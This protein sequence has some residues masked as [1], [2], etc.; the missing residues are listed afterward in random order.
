MVMKVHIDFDK[1]IWA[2]IFF[3]GIVS[4][5]IGAFFNVRW[6][7]DQIRFIK[8]AETSK[9]K[10]KEFA[11]SLFPFFIFL[12]IIAVLWIMIKGAIGLFK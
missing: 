10:L 8:Q 9:E 7:T 5:L 3:L 12:V 6:F 4:C 1:I 11:F 2:V